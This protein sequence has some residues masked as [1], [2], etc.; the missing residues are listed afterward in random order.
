MGQFNSRFE[1]RISN[2]EVRFNEEENKLTN[3]IMSY[4][5]KVECKCE[6][7]LNDKLN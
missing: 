1:Q 3:Q 7:Q 2:M 4:V 6:K 5:N